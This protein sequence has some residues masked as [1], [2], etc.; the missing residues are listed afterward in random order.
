MTVKEKLDEYDL[1]DNSI[2]KHGNLENIRDY[3][4]IG[5]LCGQAFDLEVRYVFKG[6]I[7]VN[8]KNMVEPKSF[9]MDDRLLELD[10]QDEPDYPHAFI[11]D[12]GTIV[13]PGWN[14][15]ENT[16]ELNQLESLYKIKFHKIII[17]TNAYNLNLVFHD[18]EINLLKRFE[19]QATGNF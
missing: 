17:E 18:L 3:E 4:I 1:F 5:Y 14:L 12:A 8:F 19:K 2:T 13:Y 7:E 16:D 9:S 6:C 10:R 11:W 15:E